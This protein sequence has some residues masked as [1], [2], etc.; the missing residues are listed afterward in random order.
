VR[1]S[2]VPALLVIAAGAGVAWAGASDDDPDEVFRDRILPILGS[3]DPASCTECHLAG[4]GL[5]DYLRPTA[6]ETFLSLRD[7]GLV[8]AKEP[9]KSRLLAMIR[10]APASP[11]PVASRRREAEAA[12]FEAW[13]LASAA[14]R[15]WVEAPPLDASKRAGP[16]R[17]LE[18]VRHAR[19]DEVLARFVEQ[20]WR[21]AERCASCHAPPRNAKQEKEHGP[22]VSWMKDGDAEGTMRSLLD[23]GLLD[24]DAPEKSLVLAKPSERVSHGGGKKILVGDETWT[25]W[26]AWIRDYA[27]AAKDGYA[28]AA[29]LPAPSADVAVL[30]D[31]WVR[32]ETGKELDGAAVSIE[33]FPWDAARKAWAAKPI[34]TAARE[35]NKGWQQTLYLWAPRGSDLAKDLEARKTLPKGRYLVRVHADPGYDPK[36]GRPARLASGKEVGEIE[37]DRDWPTGY[38]SMNKLGAVAR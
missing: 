3:P 15:E 26:A 1:R 16:R 29:D 24:L 6:E 13:I 9:T 5:G 19:A 2:I 27:R 17:P 14:R 8:D 28:K 25:R 32:V 4:V 35:A 7:Q 10:M 38:G 30:T 23:R 18:V 20:F 22:R 33:V 37:V 11:S 31:C 36:S 12:A 21:D 34:A